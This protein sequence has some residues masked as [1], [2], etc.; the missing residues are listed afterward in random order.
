MND[1]LNL[2]RHAIGKDHVITD[3]K[4]MAAYLTDERKRYTGKALAILRP[5]ST[6]EVSALVKLC[7]QFHV[8]VVP[9]GG[10]TGLVNGSVPDESGKAVVLSLNRLNRIRQIDPA[11]NTMIVEAGCILQHVQE[12]AEKAGRL[13]PLRLAA[14]GSCT[15]GGSLAAN[16]GGTAVLRYGNARELCMG[17]EVVTAQGDVWDNLRGLRKDNSGYDLKDLFIGS[18]GTLGIITAAVL[19]LF[20]L[21]QSTVTALA[22]VHSPHEALQLLTRTQARCGATLTGFEIMSRF[23]LQLV[24][25]HFPQITPPLPLTFPHY[26]LIEL[27]SSDTE[28]YLMD[29]LESV[30]GEAME[31]NIVLDAAVATSLAQT[32]AIWEIRERIPAAQFMEGNN[33]KHD[34]SV[35]TSRLPEFLDVTDALL[36]KHF[37]KCRPVT[38]GH[39]GD[40]NLHYNI[41]APEEVAPNDF[42]MQQDDIHR[43]VYDSVHR[44]GGSIAAEHGVGALKKNEIRRYLPE[45]ELRLMQS[46]KQALD[47]ENLMNPGRIL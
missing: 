13:Y 11:N 31:D 30:M 36:Q 39:L 17:L 3:A 29:M 20:P 35:P 26:A 19:K 44:F 9:Q 22:A 40:G 42:L 5:A 34:I 4:G 2:C 14:E 33:V 8:P 15:I 10:N 37:P 7:Q 38:F 45:V 46:V 27:S 32:R 43:V 12:A 18:E 21:P 1:F 6:E 24:A 25:R 41:S 16:A 47:P 28:T 23:S